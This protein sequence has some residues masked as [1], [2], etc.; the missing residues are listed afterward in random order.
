MRYNIYLIKNNMYPQTKLIILICK[1]ENVRIYPFY[2]TCNKL[3]W[4]FVGLRST[5]ESWKSNKSTWNLCFRSDFYETKNHRTNNCINANFNNKCLPNWEFLEVS[6]KKYTNESPIFEIKCKNRHKVLIS[7]QIK[8]IINQSYFSDF[9]ENQIECWFLKREETHFQMCYHSSWVCYERNMPESNLLA[10]TDYSIMKT[11]QKS[12]FSENGFVTK[13][14]CFGVR[15]WTFS[16]LPKIAVSKSLTVTR[17]RPVI[18]HF[19]R[20]NQ[21]KLLLLLGGLYVNPV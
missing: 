13:E 9:Q 14:G 16:N 21:R 8:Q 1:K 18:Y 17:T 20:L 19:K 10:F 6:S 3:F 7:N 5:F 11:V 12:H 15:V 4:S 2:S